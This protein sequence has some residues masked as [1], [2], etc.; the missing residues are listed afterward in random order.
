MQKRIALITAVLLL[1][2]PALTSAGFGSLQVIDNVQVTRIFSGAGQTY[3]LFTSLPGCI[4]GGGYLTVSWAI[5]NGGTVNE[6]RTKQIVATLL[7]A[8]G[9]QTTMEVRYRLNDAPT[10]WDSC[11]IDAVYL[12]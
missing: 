9:T 4:D 10:G 5:A 8:K 2:A 1:C 6:D 11:A 12:H 7:F 3:V